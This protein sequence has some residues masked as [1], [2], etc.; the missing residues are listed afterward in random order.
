[1]APVLGRMLG[2][3][4]LSRATPPQRP[5]VATLA[6]LLTTRLLA[7]AY[8]DRPPSCKA[9]PYCPAPPAPPCPLTSLLP[10]HP[11]N[12]PLGPPRGA[13]LRATPAAPEPGTSRERQK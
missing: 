2:N 11:F 9:G 7:V 6:W 1:M 8:P 5:Q 3:G 4:S 13:A 10:Q 12:A